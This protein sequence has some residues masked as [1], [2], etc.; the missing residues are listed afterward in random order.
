MWCTRVFLHGL[1]GSSQGY[2]ARFLR[3]HFPDLLVPDLRGSVAERMAYVE[4][5]LGHKPCVVL[6]GSSLGGLMAAIYACRYPAQVR[7]LVLLAPALTH[8]AFEPYTACRVTIPTYIYHGR[9]D[10]VVPLEPVQDIA[11]RVF[12]DLAFH[13]VEDDHRLTRTM[14]TLP[15]TTLLEEDPTWNTRTSEGTECA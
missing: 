9:Q 10:E 13:A 6:V 15:W 5:L 1:E 12:A 8:P 14:S 2:K 4:A 11:Q 3:T 7:R